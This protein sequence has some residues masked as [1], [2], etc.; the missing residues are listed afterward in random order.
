MGATNL[1]KKMQKILKEKEPNNFK[2]KEKIISVTSPMV[3]TKTLTDVETKTVKT[4]ALTAEKIQKYLAID[5]NSGK[6]EQCGEV[7]SPLVGK[8]MYGIALCKR[9]YSH[10]AAD[11]RKK[12]MIKNQSA[13]IPPISMK[14]DLG[15]NE[16]H[17][18]GIPHELTLIEFDGLIKKLQK[19]VEA[20]K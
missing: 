5:F 6:C 4:T 17:T 19:L 8:K 10:L 15:D 2:V 18:V 16:Y 14:I 7:S 11:L 9:C 13:P 3:N 12:K 1:A 20:F